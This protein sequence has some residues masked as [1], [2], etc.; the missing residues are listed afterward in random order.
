[1]PNLPDTYVFKVGQVIELYRRDGGSGGLAVRLI[2]DL[3]ESVLKEF[4]RDD[5]AVLLETC[6]AKRLAEEGYIHSCTTHSWRFTYD[7]FGG[8]TTYNGPPLTPK[9]YYS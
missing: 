1:M 5:S 6:L 8:A 2:K 7:R 4:V 3:P 9:R